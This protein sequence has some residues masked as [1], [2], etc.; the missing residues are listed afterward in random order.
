MKGMDRGQG[1]DN[2]GKSVMMREGNREKRRRESRS[3]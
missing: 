3:L 2:Q 1:G